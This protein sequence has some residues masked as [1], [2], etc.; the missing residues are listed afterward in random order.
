MHNSR[1]KSVEHKLRADGATESKP[2]QGQPATTSQ[3]ATIADL[4]GSQQTYASITSE[5]F[6]QL[7]EAGLLTRA[8]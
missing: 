4:R 5:V 1:T 7:L 3:Y 8:R 6:W 2:G